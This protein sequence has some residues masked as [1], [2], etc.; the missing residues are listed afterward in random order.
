MTPDD[1]PPRPTDP[2]AETPLAPLDEQASALVD[3]LLDDARAAGA[4]RSPDVAARAAAMDA[5]RASL[6]DVPPADPS[7][8][9][10]ALAAALAAFDEDAGGAVDQTHTAPSGPR[11]SVAD[12]GAHRRGRDATGR[13]VGA[14]AAAVLLVGVLI[15]G[16]VGSSSDQDTSDN[17][18]AALDTA[19]P[20]PGGDGETT[21]ESAEVSPDADAGGGS[22]AG[23]SSAD[24]P[25]PQSGAR[26]DA[27]GAFPT[28]EDLLDTAALARSAQ[29]GAAGLDDSAATAEDLVARCPSGLPDV[30]TGAD[31]AVVVATGLVD[32]VTVEVWR[33]GT[34]DA[35]RLVALDP[36][37][38]VLADRPAP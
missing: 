36:S 15:A 5:A 22:V 12:I 25:S 28:A 35:A 3:G 7:A 19:E 38:A 29:D 11:T 34:G 32:G 31:D 13:W 17:A 14:A 20:A 8:R 9:D 18:T 24:A 10:R 2:G 27:L 37:C 30:F 6:R 23:D 16:L 4:R 33:T 1:H 26:L 21:E